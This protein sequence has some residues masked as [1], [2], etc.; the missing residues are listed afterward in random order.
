MGGVNLIRQR[1]KLLT[2]RLYGDEYAHSPTLSN[3]Y[4]KHRRPA[5]SLWTET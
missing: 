4:A 2:S 5:L 1:A 3:T